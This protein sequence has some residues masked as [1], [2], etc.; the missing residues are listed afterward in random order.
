MAEMNNTTAGNPTNL[1]QIDTAGTVS[2]LYVRVTVNTHAV[3]GTLS[4]YKNGSASALFLTIPASTTGVFS[5]TVATAS[6]SVGD[7]VCV[8]YDQGANAGRPTVTNISANFTA[9]SGTSQ[10]LNASVA[11]GIALGVTTVRYFVPFGNLLSNTVEANAQASLPIAGNLHGLHMA[12][13][14][15]TW[16]GATTVRL[17]KNTGNGNQVISIGAGLTGLFADTTNNDA[18]IT[19]DVINYSVICSGAGSITFI[20]I[21]ETFDATNDTE[22]TVAS[23]L[24][25]AVSSGTKFVSIAGRQ[26]SSSTESAVQNVFGIAGTLDKI[27]CFVNTNAS[28]A[29]TTVALRKNGA[30]GTGTFTIGASTTGAF[31]DILTPGDALVA[32]D[33]VCYQYSG[34]NGTV[35]VRYSTARLVTPAT[36]GGGGSTFIAPTM[37]LLGVVTNLDDHRKKRPKRWFTPEMKK[38]FA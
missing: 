33:L 11:A 5:E 38:R 24:S 25:A 18:V 14:A 34:H 36:G 35:T 21:G 37:P 26:V 28:T 10:I 2:N 20:A 23:F 16:S 31:Q 15:N 12:V 6:V 3:N 22:S 4:L 9:T 29:V 1:V 27:G 17:R 7:N 8:Q 32:S 13:T 30:S 19:T